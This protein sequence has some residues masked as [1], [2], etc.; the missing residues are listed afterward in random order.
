MVAMG[1]MTLVP[2]AM[3]ST[4]R[5]WVTIAAIVRAELCMNVYV[6]ANGWISFL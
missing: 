5:K 4:Q 3:Q 6:H 1:L 2:C